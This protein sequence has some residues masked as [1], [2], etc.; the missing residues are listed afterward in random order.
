MPEIDF[1]VAQKLGEI[2][3]SFEIA[4]TKIPVID[5]LIASVGTVYDMTVVTRDTSG[6]KKS[7]V[8]IFNPWE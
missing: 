7:G 6:M 4:G 2:Q 8:R 3:A 1:K 5:S